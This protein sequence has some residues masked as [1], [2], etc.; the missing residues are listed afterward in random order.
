[1]SC[2][3]CSDSFPMARKGHFS[4]AGCVGKH[5]DKEVLHMKRLL[6][7]KCASHQE[8]AALFFFFPPTTLFFFFFK[9]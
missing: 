3:L 1:M 6:N 5:T 9:L 2:I 4:R 7:S 8:T